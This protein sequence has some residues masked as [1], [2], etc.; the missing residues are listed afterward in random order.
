VANIA[1]FL[2]G[3]RSYYKRMYGTIIWLL[4]LCQKELNFDLLKEQY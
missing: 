4:T 2:E 1:G 3:A